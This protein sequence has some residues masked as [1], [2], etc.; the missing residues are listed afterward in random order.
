M[1]GWEEMGREGWGRV[2]GR[3]GEGRGREGD[4]GIGV[5]RL[6]NVAAKQ[7]F[8]YL[9]STVKVPSNPNFGEGWGWG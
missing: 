6:E 7:H 5:S 1:E 3:E 2:E 8:T 4:T 9:R